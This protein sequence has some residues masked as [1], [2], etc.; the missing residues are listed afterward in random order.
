MKGI[1][2]T[3]ALARSR[4]LRR[5]ATETEKILWRELRNRGL[6]GFKFRRQAW[7]GPFIADF[8]CLEAKLVIEADGSQHGENE[9]YDVRRDAYLGREGYRVIRVWNNEVAEN[10]AGVLEAIRFALLERVP[11]PSHPAAPGG[12]LPLPRGEEE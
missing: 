9:D 1:D 3:E 5:A 10:L 7:V 12:P 4:G 8:L 2:G 11:S 6:E